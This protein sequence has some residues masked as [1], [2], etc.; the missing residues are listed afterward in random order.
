MLLFLLTLSVYINNL[1]Q[2]VYGGDSGDLILAS[3][4]KGIAHP[5]GYPLQTILGI[6]F[7]G[8]PIGET[9]AWK[10]GLIS[11]L[12]SALSIVV[13]YHLVLKL[14]KRRLLS[15]LSSLILAF[16][17]TFWLF[18][19]VVEVFALHSF[20]ILIL[21]YLAINYIE[22]KKNRTLYLI[23]FCVGLSLA[24]NQSIILLFPPLALTILL[25]NKRLILNYKLVAKSLVFLCL[26]LVPY[27]YIPLAASNYPSMNWGF[28]VNLDNLW[29]LISRQYYGWGS[30]EIVPDRFST[31]NISYRLGTYMDY[32]R[33]YINNLIPLFIITGV[34]ELIRRRKYL[35][36]ILVGGAFLLFGPFYMIYS[37]NEF[38]SFLGIATVEKFILSNLITSFI[39][40]PFGVILFQNMIAKMP[41]R[42]SLKTLF[43]TSFYL[44]LFLVAAVSFAVNQPR[45]NL[46][47][48]NLGDNLAID[49]L[50][51]LPKDT[52][53]LLRND[54]V[55]FNSLYYQ[56][57]YDFRKDIAIPGNQDGFDK[58]VKATGVKDTDILDYKIRNK[59][60]IDKNI[61]NAS[62]GPMLSENILFV[63]G[64]YEIIDNQYGRIQSVPYGLLHKLEFEKNLPYPK[65]Q[66]VKEI[67]AIVD[68]YHL[69]DFKK[70]ERVLSHSLILAD[71][72]KLYSVA[73]SRVAFYL[74][75]QYG[76]D[77]LAKK[78]L[79]KSIELDPFLV[80]EY[81]Q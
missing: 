29:F 26:G 23:A 49:I 12:F 66:Y 52:I 16:T 46:R 25:A 28:A 57:A 77:E 69:E 54:S 17:Y 70:H 7:L 9:A 81:G 10:V 20:F 39:F 64:P 4:T 33:F 6:I 3:L 61:F 2:S 63:D 55:S 45:L 32:W 34:V 36:I 58:I 56:V 48:V 24:N 30:T 11:A 51:G 15:F 1:S 42:K 76:E 8:L 50:S 60:N 31:S 5:S 40:M 47:N 72:E 14:T 78:Y 71:V 79:K 62:I 67:T 21:M 44:I 68:S 22:T 74:H 13:F 43:Q 37:G 38:S 65:E 53:A 41:I 19:E 35:V 27:V 80:I 18:A 59:G 75:E 73:L